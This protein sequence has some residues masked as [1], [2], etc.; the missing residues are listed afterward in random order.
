MLWACSRLAHLSVSAK[1]LPDCCILLGE[2]LIIE[3][4]VTGSWAY[5]VFW[6]LLGSLLQRAVTSGR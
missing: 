4:V 2:L 1:G 5:Y 3:P 6:L